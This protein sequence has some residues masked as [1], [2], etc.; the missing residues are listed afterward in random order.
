MHKI[1]VA[2]PSNIGDNLAKTVIMANM[3]CLNALKEAEDGERKKFEKDGCQIVVVSVLDTPDVEKIEYNAKKNGLN[4]CCLSAQQA[5]L[6]G[7]QK[8]VAVGPHDEALFNKLSANL[9]LFGR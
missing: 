1:L 5:G 8:I 4:S 9:R 2:I 7:D 6:G 3:T